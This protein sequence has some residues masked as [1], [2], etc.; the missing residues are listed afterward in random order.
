MQPIIFYAVLAFL[1]AHECDAVYRHEW[2][3]LYGFRRMRDEVAAK[4]FIVLHVPLFL[5]LMWLGGHP[6]ESVRWWSQLVIS[7]FMVVHTF[8]HWRLRHHAK[9]EFE[10]WES[11]S[12][13]WGGGLLGLLSS[14]LLIL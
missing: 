12:L 9:Y 13:I 7:A 11:N 14:L 6:D 4:F 3:L 1:F 2:R 8:L 5:I 10:G